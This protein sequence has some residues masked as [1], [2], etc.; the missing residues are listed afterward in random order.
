MGIRSRME[1]FWI[2]L[3]LVQSAYLVSSQEQAILPVNSSTE[4]QRCG[5]TTTCSTFFQSSVEKFSLRGFC[6][7]QFFDDGK[8]SRV[9]SNGNSLCKETEGSG[10]TCCPECL[11]KDCSSKG[12][13]WGCYGEEAAASFPQ[14]SCLYDGSCRGT[15]GSPY[16][17][18]CACCKKQIDPPPCVQS[19]K[20]QDSFD[21]QNGIR[22]FCG[23]RSWRGGDCFTNGPDEKPA[24][25]SLDAN[26]CTCCKE[27]LD[28]TCSSK[29]KQWS[30]FSR[31]EASLLP[32]GAC[33]F[34]NSCPRTPN[35][36]YEDSSCACCDTEYVPPCDQTEKCREAFPETGVKGF[37]SKG[38]L[39]GVDC[40]PL[41][42]I[43]QSFC[44]FTGCSCCKECFDMTC[45]EKGEGWSCY[46]KEEAYALPQGSCVFDESCAKSP[47]SPCGGAC[48]CC[49]KDVTI[50]PPPTTPAPTCDTTFQCKAAYPG[51]GLRGFCGDKS[52]FGGECSGS[53]L[54]SGK[55]LCDREGCT[56]CK[57]CLD[58]KCSSKGKGWSCYN[59]EAAAALPEGSCVFDRSCSR[60][61][62]SPYEDSAC[63]C[64]KP[65]EPSIPCED[66]GCSKEW[67]GLG[68]CVNVSNADWAS[69][70]ASFNLSV[71]GLPGKCGPAPC[72]VCLQKKPCADQG[73]A[74]F[75]GGAGVCLNVLDPDFAN[76]T[77]FLDFVAG[78]REDL[79][80]AG[81]R[82]GC[83]SCFKKKER[84][85]SMSSCSSGMKDNCCEEK[86]VGEVDYILT[87]WNEAEAK[88]SGCTSGCIYQA[89]GQE[90]SSVCFAPGSLP[91]SCGQ[92]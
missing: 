82:G 5:T 80:G 11:E 25:P 63:A 70:D 88:A 14:G 40:L 48:A 6:G 87:G 49:K 72:C 37:C 71:T 50:L 52:L 75:H 31:E 57:E 61:S 9:D 83:C 10:C 21:G 41:D 58:E 92:L 32:K 55:L 8:C 86:T 46:S 23:D 66:E 3:V 85:L 78:G 47:G 73:C 42:G 29:G 28:T 89:K 7:L 39:S 56:C 62:G 2:P 19:T 38:Q 67:N 22:G 35:S 69:V 53:D 90:R 18:E 12:E 33:V 79:C 15:P 54:P 51:T 64:C 45:S 24:C 44:N 16:G 36:P 1:V 4:L 13:G 84:L 59:K 20:C 60:A 43:G 91:V 65:T 34:D 81:T 74:R 77:P 27:C 17:M 26:A 76:R 68:A 30:C